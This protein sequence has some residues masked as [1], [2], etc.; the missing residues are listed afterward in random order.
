ML[1]IPELTNSDVVFGNVKHMPKMADTDLSRPT[2]AAALALAH[3][4]VAESARDGDH[5]APTADDKR[6]GQVMFARLL[7]CVPP[8]DGGLRGLDDAERSVRAARYRIR[9]EIL[10]GIIG[11]VPVWP[12]ISETEQQRAAA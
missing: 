10:A 2:Y 1:P 3:R 6:A 5:S 7:M 4:A 11:D 12:S 9:P 8:E